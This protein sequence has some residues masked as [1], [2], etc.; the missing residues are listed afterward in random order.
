MVKK[1]DVLKENQEKEWNISR[2]DFPPNFVFGVATS[3]YQVSFFSS[4][5]FSKIV[6]CF[7]YL[8]I[9]VLFLKF[10]R[11]RTSFFLKQINLLFDF[12]F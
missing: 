9:S 1:E 6:I 8:F 4:P 12:H 3:A 10:V 7:I 5:L 2:N 11:Q